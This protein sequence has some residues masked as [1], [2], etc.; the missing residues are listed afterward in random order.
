MSRRTSAPQEFAERNVWL[1]VVAVR[2]GKLLPCSGGKKVEFDPPKLNK[3][4]TWR[5]GAWTA[6]VRTP[7]A[8]VCGY[9]VTRNPAAWIPNGGRY[10]IY[11]VECRGKCSTSDRNNKRAYGSIRLLRPLAV[12]DLSSFAADDASFGVVNAAVDNR[13][14]VLAFLAQALS[15]M[16][17]LSVR[18]EYPQAYEYLLRFAKS[19]RVP[20]RSVD[21]PKFWDMYQRSYYFT[22]DKYPYMAHC[23]S[24]CRGRRAPLFRDKL[25]LE[26]VFSWSDMKKRVHS[27]LLVAEAAEAR[28]DMRTFRV[29]PGDGQT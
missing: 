3:N 11:W 13:I 12:S 18:R 17:K 24:A 10:A 1:K 27:S 29:V 23:L 6:P 15:E 5:A 26:W 21:G 14:I 9:H 2:A 20:R 19:G 7:V 28:I 25:A 22:P 8:C 4:G 16:R